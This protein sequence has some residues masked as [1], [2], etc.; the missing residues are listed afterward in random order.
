MNISKKLVTAAALLLVT[1]SG[2]QV[3]AQEVVDTDTSEVNVSFDI[4]ATPLRINSVSD[5]IFGNHP[6]TVVEQII[7]ATNPLDLSLTDNR[8]FQTSQG[9]NLT[10]TLSEFT[11]EGASAGSLPGAYITLLSPTAT[12]ESTTLVEPQLSTP[13]ILQSNGAEALVANAD[14]AVDGE[15]SG[16]GTWNINWVTSENITLTILENT[17]SPGTHNAQVT[18]TLND[19]PQ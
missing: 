15:S 5:I 4:E 7:D 11:E 2:T 8:G 13:V 18:W 1:L 12:G 17:A 3:L 9:W 6:L 19:A 10:A 14:R 16:V